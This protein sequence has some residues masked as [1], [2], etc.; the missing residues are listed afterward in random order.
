M[1]FEWDEKKRQSN[2]QKH[3]IDFED[4]GKVFKGITLTIL[5]NR[6]DYGEQRYI[7]MGLLGDV[8]VVVAHTEIKTMIRI[9]S[10]RKATKNEQKI[11]YKRFTY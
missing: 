7:T 10:M 1:V 6:F 4:A 3:G 8:V 11:F 5:D 2:I 9:I